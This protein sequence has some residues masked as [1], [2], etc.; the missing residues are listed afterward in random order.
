[1][2]KERGQRWGWGLVGGGVEMMEVFT[3]TRR[4]QGAKQL[5]DEGHEKIK[6]HLLLTEGNFQIW[7]Q[8]IKSSESPQAFSHRNN[9]FTCVR[10]YAKRQRNCAWH[11]S[12]KLPSSRWLP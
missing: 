6:F 2:E 12:A 10:V 9:S 11:L 3:P 1:M 5:R 4:K 8:V 7:L